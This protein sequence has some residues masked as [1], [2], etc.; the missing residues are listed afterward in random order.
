MNIEQHVRSCLRPR[1]PDSHK[2]TYGTLLAVCGSDGMA[3]AA[4]LSAKAALRCGV[5]LVA[6]ATPRCVYP[7]VAA[8][9]PE[10]VFVPLSQ[11]ENGTLDIAAL[12][13][14]RPWQRKATACLIGCG[15]GR[16]DATTLAV[17]ALLAEIGCPTVVDADGINA[18]ALHTMETETA[19]PLI[20]TPHPAEMARLLGCSVEE[21][22]RDRTAAACEAARRYHAVA[23]LKGHRT[24][25]A[26][27]RGVQYINESGNAGMATA[28]SGDV[29]AGMIG[30][31]LAQGLSAVDAAICGVYLHGTV[32]DRVAARLSQR[33]LIASDLIEELPSLFLTFE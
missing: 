19:A 33:S 29:L 17:H 12:G 18:L 10:A 14:L 2:G 11:T 26:D 1:D 15:L 20:L 6:C 4:A 7:L 8:A 16:A 21:V 13:Q 25:V 32:G 31:L 22:Q 3:G 28:G 30:G 24:V 23:V 9:V 5:G 27:E